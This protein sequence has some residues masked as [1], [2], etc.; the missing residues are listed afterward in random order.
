MCCVSIGAGPC[1][2]QKANHSTDLRTEKTTGRWQVFS[3]SQGCSYGTHNKK[4]TPGYIKHFFNFMTR[5]QDECVNYE[6]KRRPPDERKKGRFSRR[7]RKKCHI[8][9]RHH[10]H[11]HR[12]I[13]STRNPRTTCT[14]T[15]AEKIAKIRFLCI[16]CVL[17][18]TA[19][20]FK[21]V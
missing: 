18:Q 12:I 14:G 2:L 1:S 15:L 4:F 7:N 17:T 13:H 19:F 3:A 8:M 16:F 6:D 5:E 11:R 21:N 9:S 20:H 10:R